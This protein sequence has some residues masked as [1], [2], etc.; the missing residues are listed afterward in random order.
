MKLRALL[1]G[2]IRFQYKY[3]FYFL[4]LVFSV[5]YIALLYALPQDW[6][7]KAG[8]LMIFTDPAAMG[9]FFMGAIVLLEKGER[10]LDSIAVAPIRPHE[11]MLSK[12]LSLAVISVVVALAVALAGG[13]RLHPFYFVAGVLLGSCLFSCVGLIIASH[14]TTL[15]AFLLLSIPAEIVINLP[16]IAYLFGYRPAWLILHPGVCMIELCENGALALPCVFILA[17]WTTLCG[18][19]ARRSVIK[20]LREVGGVKL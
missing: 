20:L 10:V 7:S 18:V 5:L 17:L 8:V 4:Y 14:S 13:I 3:G 2:D 19:L 11:Y 16:A 12:L 1:I 15:N 6:L 9:L